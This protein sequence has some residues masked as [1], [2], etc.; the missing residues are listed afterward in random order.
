MRGFQAAALG[1]AGVDPPLIAERDDCRIVLQTSARRAVRRVGHRQQFRDVKA[2]AARADQGHLRARHAASG[3]HFHIACHFRMLDARDRRRARHDAGGQQHVV[4]AHEVGCTRA[5]AQSCLHAEPLEAR[6][7]VTQR[8]RKFF[9]AGNAPRE[10][11][12]A[13]DFRRRIE[14]GDVM[15]AL[16]CGDRCRH[17]RGAGADDG[18][19]PRRRG[20]RE[21]PFR[22]ATGKGIHQA[23]RNLPGEDLVEAC[24]VARDAC[25]D[26]VGAAGGCLVHEIGI[27]E[28][29]SSHRNHVGIAA[30]DHIVAH[31]RIVD[32]VGRDQ[33]NLHGAAQ[34][35]RDPR[36][37]RARHHRRNGGDARFMPAHTG[38]DDR[39]ARA[40]HGPGQCHHLVPRAATLDQVEHRQPEDQ[41]EV[42]AHRFARAAHDLH[43]EANAIL[44]GTAPLV[45]AMIGLGCH[46]LV[47]E[48]TLGAHDLDPVVAGALGQL[49]AADKRGDRPAHTPAGQSP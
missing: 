8:L 36:K 17:A 31:A 35:A 40:L 15:S 2:D 37:G 44:E 12:L 26:F 16:G 5:H 49:R 43:R 9:L 24:L 48:V 34:A 14:Q 21:C 30:S 42:A 4:E 6:A 19:F 10:I 13:A 28:E 20:R 46:E 25:I 3:D 33:R 18:N 22:F 29:W 47:D 41:D 45:V 32:P 39:G 23:R 11:E 1:I 7:V 38:V 27:G